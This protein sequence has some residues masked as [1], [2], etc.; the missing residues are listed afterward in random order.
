MPL[1]ASSLIWKL[2]SMAS[3]KL[4]SVYATEVSAANAIGV[5]QFRLFIA[6]AVAMFLYP[7]T[8]CPW[9]C[10]KTS[11]PTAQAIHSIKCPNFISANAHLAV[12]MHAVKLTQWTLLSSPL[13]TTHATLHR[14]RSEERRVG[15]A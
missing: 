15:K 5:V 1:M 8:S 13:G 9:Y 14:T 3:A 2:C 6:Q 11:F 12:L 10:Q 7:K 4:S